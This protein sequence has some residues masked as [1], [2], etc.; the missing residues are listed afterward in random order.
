MV[1][2]TEAAYAILKAEGRPLTTKEITQKAISRNLIKTQGKTPKETMYASI[3][4]ENK[5]KLKRGAD[6]RFKKVGIDTWDL[7]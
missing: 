6:P 7:V 3:Y 1:S 5:R 4:L 2:F